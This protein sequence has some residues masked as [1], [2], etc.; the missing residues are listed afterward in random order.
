MSI[1]LQLYKNRQETIWGD[2]IA[3]SSDRIRQSASDRAQEFV[4]V[5]T[6]PAIS[7]IVA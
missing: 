1:C 4:F 7:K 6:C 3:S 2:A 5:C